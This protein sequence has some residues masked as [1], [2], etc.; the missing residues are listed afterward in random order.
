MHTPWPPESLLIIA[1][2]ML[3]CLVSMGLFV[4]RLQRTLE[5]LRN[6]AEQRL[7]E[8]ASRMSLLESRIDRAG[9]TSRPAIS[10]SDK[11][12]SQRPAASAR[13]DVA[14][15]MRQDD[16]H[17]R[18]PSGGPTLIE[19]PDLAAREHEP[20]PQAEREL[21]RRHAEVWTLAEAGTP[22]ADIARQTGHPIGQVELIVGL[23]RRLLT[24]GGR[25]DHAR[26]D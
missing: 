25:I 4:M 8:L 9:N 21:V 2:F 17:E 24:S 10:S 3:F 13:V 22:P 6:R 19:I 7:D 18:V 23:F 12:L 1:L 5:A 16:S 26:H 15:S 14:S 11:R 20:D